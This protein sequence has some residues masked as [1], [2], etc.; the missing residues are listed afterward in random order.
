MKMNEKSLPPLA[1]DRRTEYNFYSKIH[2]GW[3]FLYPPF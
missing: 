2:F 3:R 1:P